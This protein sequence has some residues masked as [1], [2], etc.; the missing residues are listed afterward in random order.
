MYSSHVPCCNKTPLLR[1]LIKER[2][3]YFGLVFPRPKSPY[4]DR[5]CGSKQQAAADMA[6]GSVH[7]ECTSQPQ[8]QTSEWK[9]EVTWLQTYKVF[10]QWCASSSKVIPPKTSQIAPLTGPSVKCLNL[11]GTCSLKPLHLIEIT[12][13]H[14]TFIQ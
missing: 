13:K 7:W 9:V 11:W 1:H 8:V 5:R 2:I 4:Q 3:S 12:K 14:L 10:L 6:A